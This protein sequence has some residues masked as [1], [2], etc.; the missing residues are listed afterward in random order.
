MSKKQTS[1]GAHFG[2]LSTNNRLLSWARFCFLA[3]HLTIGLTAL[4]STAFAQA[5]FDQCERAYVLCL[6]NSGHSPLLGVNCDDQY[7]A[8]IEAC[9]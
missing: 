9:L 8:C 7:D 6:A 5:C 1:Q 4:S 3:L 2:V